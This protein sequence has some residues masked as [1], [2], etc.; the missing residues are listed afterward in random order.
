MAG[1]GS[2]FCIITCVCVCHCL[3]NAIHCMGVGQNI[4]SLQRVCV[5]AR[6]LGPNISKMARDRGSVPMGH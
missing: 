5:Y 4:K 6:D 3:S 2:F 1:L